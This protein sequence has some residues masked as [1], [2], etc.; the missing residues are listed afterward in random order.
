MNGAWGIYSDYP[1]QRIV[2][3]D[4]QNGLF[5]FQFNRALFEVPSDTT[6]ILYPNPIRTGES[7]TV[8]T[9]GDQ[10][11]EFSVQ[12]FDQL[13]QILEE[14]AVS[15]A[16]FLALDAPAT[17]GIYCIKINYINYLGE[18]DFTVRRLTVTN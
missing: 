11:S 9:P 12:V 13:G 15:K 3:S 6:F 16:S 1:S 17:A 4:R 5:L 8:R 2:V 7:F 10:L 14:Q 18:A